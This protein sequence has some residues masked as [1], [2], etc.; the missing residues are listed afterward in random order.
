MCV[1]G[2]RCNYGRLMQ[3]RHQGWTIGARC[4]PRE[5]VLLGVRRAAVA[6]TALPVPNVEPRKAGHSGPAA[7]AAPRAPANA[8]RTECPCRRNN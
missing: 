2:C 6:G 4:E 7:R 3:L 8:W 1:I 5:R